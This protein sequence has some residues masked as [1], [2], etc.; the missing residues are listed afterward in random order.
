MI[1][2]ETTGAFRAGYLLALG[3][4]FG[5]VGLL[6]SA[7]RSAA[8]NVLFQ[9]APPAVSKLITWGPS[10]LVALGGALTLGAGLVLSFGWLQ[11]RG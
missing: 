7:G 11:K 5:L 3:A 2:Q 4:A 8:Q 6:L 9:D 10:S 1:H